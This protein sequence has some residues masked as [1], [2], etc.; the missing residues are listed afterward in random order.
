[1][2]PDPQPHP[3]AAFTVCIRPDCTELPRYCSAVCAYEL[4]E[5]GP[6]LKGAREL[7]K[8]AADVIMTYERELE[9]GW[10]GAEASRDGVLPAIGAFLA[11]RAGT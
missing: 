7:L 3:A 9:S 6:T 11:K 2:S 4:E 1:M 8:R 5:A 10:P